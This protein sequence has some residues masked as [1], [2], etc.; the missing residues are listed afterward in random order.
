MPINFKSFQNIYPD[1]IDAKI[2]L[3]KGA[4]PLSI[5]SM[6]TIAGGG[7]MLAYEGTGRRQR[8][9]AS[10]IAEKNTYTVVYGPQGSGKTRMIEKFLTDYQVNEV[11]RCTYPFTSLNNPMPSTTKVI[12]VDEFPVCANF[13]ALMKRFVDELGTLLKVHVIVGVQHNRPPFGSYFKAGAIRVVDVT[14]TEKIKIDD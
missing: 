9:V 4:K 6:L 10:R 5:T 3:E 7:K 2:T 8:I 1:A 12:V 11:V 14:A 13:S